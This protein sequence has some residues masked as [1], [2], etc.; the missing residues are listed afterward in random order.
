MDWTV[1][2]DWPR[3]AFV[4]QTVGLGVLVRALARTLCPSPFPVHALRITRSDAPNVGKATSHE[5]RA[6]ESASMGPN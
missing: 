6:P 1:P 4:A 2:T 5:S 3:F